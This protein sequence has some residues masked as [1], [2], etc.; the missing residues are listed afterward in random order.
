MVGELKLSLYG[1]RDA[2]MNCAKKHTQHLNKI[3]FQKG[4]AS[5]CNFV[6]ESRNT[7][8][9]CHGDDFIIVALC[10]EIEWLVREMAKRV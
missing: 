5:A 9:T 1:T 8:L 3:G 10:K 7:R 4:R 6:H 2:A